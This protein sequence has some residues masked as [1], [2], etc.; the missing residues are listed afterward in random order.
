MGA[1]PYRLTAV[2][3]RAMR[4]HAVLMEAKRDV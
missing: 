4:R 1:Q 2:L 3:V